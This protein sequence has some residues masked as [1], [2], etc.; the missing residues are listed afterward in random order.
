LD[1]S[2]GRHIIVAALPLAVRSR[3]AHTDAHI[4]RVADAFCSALDEVM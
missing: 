4:D 2:A 1:G 3:A